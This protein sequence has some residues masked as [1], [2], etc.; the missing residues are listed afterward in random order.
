MK[1]TTIKNRFSQKDQQSEQQQQIFEI[2]EKTL[3]LP[4]NPRLVERYS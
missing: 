1:M 2:F 4:F 3:S